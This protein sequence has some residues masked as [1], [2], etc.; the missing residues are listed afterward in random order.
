MRT[1]CLDLDV[2]RWVKRL[3]DWF[4]F[5]A[6]SER[7][8]AWKDITPG[9]PAA[10]LRSYGTYASGAGRQDSWQNP[11]TGLGTDRDKVYQGTY[12]APYRLQDTE[13]L[14]IFNGSD[15]GARVVETKPQEMMKR[16]YE[17]EVDGDTELD[18]DE[19]KELR[20]TAVKLRLDEQVTAGGVWGGLFGGALAIIGAQDGQQMD[21]PLAED[22]IQ[23][24]R[25]INVV[26]RRFIYVHSYY[27]NPLEPNYGLP[28]KYLVVNHVSGSGGVTSTVVVH[29]S[30]CIR[31]DGARTDIL[32]RQ[33]L[34]GWTWSLLQRPYDQLRAFETGFQAVANLMSD[35]SQAVFKLQNLI[36]MIA[37][38]EKDVLQERM[39]LVDM[40]RSV[41]RA[42]LIDAEAEDFERKPTTFSGLP[43]LLDRFM[44]RLSAA[45]GIPVTILL[46]RSAAGMNATGDADFRAFYDQLAV[47]QTTVLAPILQRLYR[48]L[49]LAKDSATGGADVEFNIKFKALWAPT[50]TEQATIEKTTAEKDQIYMTTGVLSPE[51]VKLA[52]YGKGGFSIET[53]IDVEKAKAALGDEEMMGNMI[54]PPPELLSAAQQGEQQTPVT[55]MPGPNGSAGGDPTQLPPA[56]APPPYATNKNPMTQ[57]RQM[58][59]PPKVPGKK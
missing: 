5:W 53:K 14:A 22:R 7:G 4:K 23:T 30:R 36:S 42:V 3:T 45:V 58:Y 32:T 10:A 19:I 16:G 54:Q 24:I 31:F 46:G 9:T 44:M 2:A 34:A 29:E 35:A 12:F 49:S 37:A 51:E 38:G 40:S 18:E 8:P 17:L 57:V 11:N 50:D 26:D 1:A 25:Y 13:L 43:E 48:L 39:A 15:I 59:T 33:Q 28:E 47:E 20:K 56:G 41:C 21:Q 52:R 6:L 27:A 55:G